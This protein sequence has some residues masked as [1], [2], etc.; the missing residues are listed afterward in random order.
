MLGSPALQEWIRALASVCAG[1][2]GSPVT[3]GGLS[4]PWEQLLW[5]TRVEALRQVPQSGQDRE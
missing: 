3:L 5:A 4:A 2:T 1:V